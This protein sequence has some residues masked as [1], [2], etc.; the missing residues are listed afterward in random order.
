M[1]N[2]TIDATIVLMAGETMNTA[3]DVQNGKVDILVKN[4]KGTVAYKG[5]DVESGSF[6]FG[7][8]E[9]GSYTFSI[10][11]TKAKG[12]VHFIRSGK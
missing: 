3:I 11:G 10:T 1:L 12:S 2:S 5:D 7:I 4:E 8:T 6:S 9:D